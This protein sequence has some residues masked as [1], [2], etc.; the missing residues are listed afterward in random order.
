[1]ERRSSTAFVYLGEGQRVKSVLGRNFKTNL[2]SALGVPCSL[3]T[4][5]HLRVNLV[6]VCSRED[7]QVVG[8]SDRSNVLRSGVS[9]SGRVVGNGS[10]LDIISSGSTSQ[11]T[12]LS[13]YSVDVRGRAFEEIEEGSAMEVGLLEVKVEPSKR[14][15]SKYRLSRSHILASR[16]SCW[17]REDIDP[18]PQP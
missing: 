2:V 4:S 16:L 10:L 3:S 6:V 11:E 8:S 5:L 14:S 15:Q 13:N 18:E 9:D 7:A 12:I 1:M 17:S